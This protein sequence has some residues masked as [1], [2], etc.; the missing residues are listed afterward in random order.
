[1]SDLKLIPRLLSIHH[2]LKII[3]GITGLVTFPDSVGTLRM[4]I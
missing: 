2:L 4:D 1:M 3:F